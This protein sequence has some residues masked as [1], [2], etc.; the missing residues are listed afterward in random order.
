MV[1]GAETNKNQTGHRVEYNGSQKK[2]TVHYY[3]TYII[4]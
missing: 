4:T 2:N 1:T 3:M